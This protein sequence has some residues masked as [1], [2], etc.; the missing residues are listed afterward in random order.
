MFSGPASRCVR[1]PGNRARQGDSDRK[2]GRREARTSA[3]AR[4]ARGAGEASARVSGRPLYKRWRAHLSVSCD[5]M[6]GVA[7]DVPF[8][9]RAIEMMRASQKPARSCVRPALPCYL[10]N[11]FQL[12]RGAER[13]ACD[14]IHQAARALVFSE[15]VLQQLGSGVSDLRLIADISRSG[16]R[17]AEAD[18]AR[19]SVERS[20]VLFRDS[21]NVERR[22]LSR[23][24]TG[25]HVELRADAPSESRRADA[26]SESRPAAFRGK[27]SAKKEQIV[28]LHGFY[29]RA[30]RLRRHGELDAEFVQ[31]LLGAGGPR[32]FAGHHLPT[33]APP[34]TC[35]TSP[36]T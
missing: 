34:S 4:E 5:K 32:A 25:F 14:A 30:E 3:M 36:V 13:K 24:A 22:E 35:S 10:E 7:S 21:E 18:D 9:Q 17:H 27:H 6:S 16:H 2:A 29:V 1:S 12:D 28:R 23:L 15:D 33:C 11:D 8:L 19:H 26:P 20:Q 31:P